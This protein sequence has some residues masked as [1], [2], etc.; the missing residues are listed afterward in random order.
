MLDTLKRF[1]AI[2]PLHE[3]ATLAASFYDDLPPLATQI[4]NIRSYDKAARTTSIPA[5]LGV[6]AIQRAV[7][8]ISH[9]VG[10]LSMQGWRNGVPMAETPSI[11]SRPDP[12]QDPVSFYRSVAFGL[13]V[14]GESVLWIARR[15][16]LGYP[17]SL[18][19]VPIGELHIEA[20]QRDRLRPR[21]QWGDRTST[22]YSLANTSGDF[23]HIVYHRYPGELHGVGPLQ[24]CGAA[25]SVAVEAQDWAGNFYASGG[26][27]PLVIKS[28]VELDGS[29]DPDT[30]LTEAQQLK[31]AWMAGDNNVP[32]VI[33][34]GIDEIQQLDYN[35]ATAAALEARQ[36][37][38]GD[39][40]RMYGIPGTLL[41]Y[42][43]PGSSLTYQSVPDV[44][45][46]FL[47]GCLQP[48]YLEPI[49]A[50][51][52][53]LLPRSG[54]GRFNT[55][56]L[57]R[58]DV[59][60]RYEAYNYGIPLGVITTEEARREEG[61]LPGDIET[62]P[63][64]PA[65]PAAIP[66]TLPD[67]TLQ[68]RS[69]SLRCDG[70][71]VLRGVL[72]PCNALLAETGVFTGVCRRCGKEYTGA[73]SAVSAERSA[74]SPDIVLTATVV[75]PPPPDPDREM[76]RTMAEALAV[77]AARPEPA[78]PVVNVD[79]QPA[80]VR[81]EFTMPAPDRTPS[82]KRIRRDEQGLISII[83]EG[84]A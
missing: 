5:A 22:R 76:L 71:R 25:V 13:A 23:V 19:D 45:I 31:A 37:S 20:N 34:P 55:R 17:L 82:V 62:M 2:E 21:Y 43:M 52:S 68:S 16:S 38:N 69:Q 41:E 59:K 73:V 7:T 48:S 12:Y 56:G 79:V 80:Q 3:R 65:P 6:P 46:E 39:A 36:F 72:R 47:R 44:W 42:N 63:V 53:D 77:I 67:D 8:L 81:N 78:P 1:L 26:V 14:Y 66:T 50:Q 30:G 10:S 18:I 35:P 9:T 27:P 24:M 70:R 49:E 83:E 84:V 51:M 61:Y 54:T 28:A 40:A 58:A 29:T 75:P 57:Q 15:D 60:T 33:D 64:A 74:V 11:L 32:K 4:A